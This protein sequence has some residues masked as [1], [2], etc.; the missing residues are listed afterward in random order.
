MNFF[1][2]IF[3]GKYNRTKTWRKYCLL[4]YRKV[5]LAEYVH[6][7]MLKLCFVS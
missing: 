2:M 7:Q 5:W 4:V 6:L 1:R 3:T